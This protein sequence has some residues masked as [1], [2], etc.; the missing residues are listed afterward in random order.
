MSKITTATKKLLKSLIKHW[1]ALEPTP[2]VLKHPDFFDVWNP[3]IYDKVN[4]SNQYS[5]KK[6]LQAQEKD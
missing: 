2:L 1:K 6:A 5:Y 3:T 4:E